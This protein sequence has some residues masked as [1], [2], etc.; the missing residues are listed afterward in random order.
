MTASGTGLPG[1]LVVEP[2]VFAD[3]RGWFLESWSQAAFERLG[4][5]VSFV[6][7]NHSY[8]ARKGTLRG[9]HFQNPPFAQAKLVRCTRGAVLDVAADVRKGSPTYLRWVAVELTAE[10]RKALWIPRGFAHGFVTLVDDTEVQYKADAP[11][12]PASERSVR[13]DDPAL[14]IAWGVADPVL[15]GKDRNAPTIADCDC[16][17]VYEDADAGREEA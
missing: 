10:N 9:L 6:Q 17:F 11:Y 7:D 15:N 14:G 12:A 13:F 4:I 16:G 8:S 3:A 5:L 2:R 1:V